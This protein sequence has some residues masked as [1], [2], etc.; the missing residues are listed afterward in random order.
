MIPPET[1]LQ[2]HTVAIL[3]PIVGLALLAWLRPSGHDRRR[4]ATGLAIITVL[5]VCY[6]LPWDNFLIRRGVWTYGEGV[7]AGRLWA[8]PVG[9]ALF[10][11][12]QPIFTALWLS[13]FSISTTTPLALSTRQR[14]AGI[15]AGV[16]VGVVGAGLLT[17]GSTFYLGAILAWAAPI[18][19][20]QWGFG[21]T[22]L[23]HCRRTVGL[24]VAVPTL[25]LWVVDWT[26][27]SL[28]LWTIS[29][30]YTVGIAPLGLPVEEMVF[31]LVTNLFVIQGLV[32][33]AWLLDRWGDWSK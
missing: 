10:F 30:D 21:W 18:F 27:I 13:R 5:A 22:Q 25:Y 17:G 33:Y 11:V 29:P 8:V 20:L 31:F 12:L 24:A 16:G 26:A 19:A 7:V 4:A 6:T 3:P 23:W 32:L 14:A 28:E 1:Y 9:E 15:L 2:F